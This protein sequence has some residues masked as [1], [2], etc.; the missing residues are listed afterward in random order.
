MLL[1]TGSKSSFS[2]EAFIMSMTKSVGQ[3]DVT[4]PS[5]SEG[6]TRGAFLLPKGARNIYLNETEDSR[7][8][9][10]EW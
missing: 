7:N 10:G 2:L 8:V 3:N 5:D 1:E 6:K 4:N 9:M